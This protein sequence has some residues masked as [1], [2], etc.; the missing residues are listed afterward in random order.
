MIQFTIR[1]DH[2]QRKIDEYRE[3]NV[4]VLIYNGFKSSQVCYTHFKGVMLRHLSGTLVGSNLLQ[5]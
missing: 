5:S 1:H 4:G 2:I 3:R